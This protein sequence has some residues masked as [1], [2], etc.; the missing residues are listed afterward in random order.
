[1]VEERAYTL[2][3]GWH[4]KGHILRGMGGIIVLRLELRWKRYNEIGNIWNYDKKIDV[5]SVGRS[6]DYSEL[7]CDL[8]TMEITVIIY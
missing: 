8:V 2:G 3:H 4:R 6:Q 7:R 5:I 1:M